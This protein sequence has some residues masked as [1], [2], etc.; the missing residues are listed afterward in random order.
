MV[1]LQCVDREAHKL[2]AQCDMLPPGRV[3]TGNPEPGREGTLRA[4][5]LSDTMEQPRGVSSLPRA[6]AAESRHWHQE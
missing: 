2:S 5:G 1:R 4:A 3:S 6:A